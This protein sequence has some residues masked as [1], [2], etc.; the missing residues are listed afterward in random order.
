MNEHWKLFAQ[1]MINTFMILIKEPCSSMNISL[2]PVV[3]IW[4]YVIHVFQACFLNGKVPHRAVL[5]HVPLH[6]SHSKS[7]TFWASDITWSWY[8]GVHAVRSYQASIQSLGLKT[9]K[10]WTAVGPQYTVAH[11]SCVFALHKATNHCTLSVVFPKSSVCNS[12]HDMT[13][14]KSC[15][16]SVKW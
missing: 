15:W 7:Q 13:Q 9:S 6:L 12:S 2:E 5:S 10:F 16:K 8:M 4:V 11:L 1:S 14:W 3:M